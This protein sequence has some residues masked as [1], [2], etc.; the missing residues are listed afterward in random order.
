MDH[1]AHEVEAVGS[2]GLEVVVD[3]G[4]QDCPLVALVVGS[5]DRD[6]VLAVDQ[7]SQILLSELVFRL[8]SLPLA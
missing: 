5:T 7:A 6:E 4:A 2:T 3:Q 8:L 1:G